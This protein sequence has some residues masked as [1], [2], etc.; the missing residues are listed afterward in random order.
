MNIVTKQQKITV[1]KQNDSVAL[2]K[3]T[4]EQREVPVEQIPSANKEEVK[5]VLGLIAYQELLELQ[6][7]SD[8]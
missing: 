4:V 2:K 6:R 3:V 1:E 8:E 5:S 7:R